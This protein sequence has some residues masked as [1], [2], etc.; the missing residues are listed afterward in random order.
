MTRILLAGGLVALIG[1]MI[2]N[3]TARGDDQP[4]PVLRLLDK[5]APL[6]KGETEKDIPTLTVYRP[7]PGKANGC[8]IVICPGGGYG[9]LAVDHEGKQIGEWLSS[10]GITAFELHYR[11][12]PYRHPVPLVDVQRALRTVRAR[13][14]EYGIDTTR[15][16]ILGFSAG[17]HLASTAATHFHDKPVDRIDEV[18]GQNARPDF[19]VLAYPVIS[20]KDGT[21]HG[22]SK[23]NLLGPEPDPKLVESLSNETAVS[24]RTPPVFLFHTVEDKAVPVENSLRFFEA[25]RSKN[26]P[27]EMHIFEH[28][29]HGVGLAQDDPVLAEWPKLCERWMTR[30]GFLTAGAPAAPAPQSGATSN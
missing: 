28:G 15:V 29:R 7:A 18:D 9:G 20:L 10:L 17:G 16:G 1:G 30:H 12:A 4:R 3:G 11:L 2:V 13:A 14:G 19:A 21:T 24:E 6:A 8:A 22:G 26:V 27:V 25:C 5:A 23:K